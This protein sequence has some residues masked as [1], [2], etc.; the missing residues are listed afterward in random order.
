MLERKK[1]GP[2]PRGHFHLG[3]PLAQ[4]HRTAKF[5][6][7]PTEI[8]HCFGDPHSDPSVDAQ[9]S[10]RTLRIGSRGLKLVANMIEGAAGHNTVRP[11][12]SWR[13]CCRN[14]PA[15]GVMP[16]QM[17]GHHQAL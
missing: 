13:S 4:T 3:K 9:A 17:A 5:G 15:D 7:L 2:W 8:V 6:V 12:R 16:S 10:H 11:G 1:T 14:L